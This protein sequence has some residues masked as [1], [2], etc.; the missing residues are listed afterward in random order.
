MQPEVCP[1]RAQ[2]LAADVWPHLPCAAGPHRLSYPLQQ[3]ALAAPGGNGG[4]L[5][6]RGAR[7]GVWE[8]VGERGV[9]LRTPARRRGRGGAA[10]FR[11]WEAVLP[12]LA[13]AGL[14]PVA[15]AYARAP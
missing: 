4:V 2:P 14:R 1:A 15:A 11:V 10:R 7:P 3:L 12:E 9:E 13:H 6:R 8:V 5:L